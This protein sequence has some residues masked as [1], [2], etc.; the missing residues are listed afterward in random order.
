MVYLRLLKI[1]AAAAAT[2]MIMTAPIAMYVVV[3]CALVG[4]SGAV[5]AVG[6]VVGGAVGACVGG[7]ISVGAG[8]TMA[9]AA[10]FAIEIAVP[11]WL[12]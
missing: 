2:I 12:W 7:V 4:G 11:A 10:A 5:V 6:F 3:G 8:V 1:K 9:G